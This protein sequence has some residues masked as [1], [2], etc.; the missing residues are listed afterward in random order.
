MWNI[1]F[2]FENI[3]RFLY[4]MTWKLFHLN[5][6]KNPELYI[7]KDTMYCYNY[8]GKDGTRMRNIEGKDIMLPYYGID[9]CIF[10][11]NLWNMSQ[12][13]LCMF[14]GGDCLMDFCKTCGI[15]ENW[16]EIEALYEKN[17]A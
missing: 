11:K 1:I 12:M 2:F 14:N 6:Y 3:I 17:N 9:S 10:H 5:L 7:P 8:N 13:D 4:R 16:D 15:N